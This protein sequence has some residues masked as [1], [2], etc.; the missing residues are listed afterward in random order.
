MKLVPNNRLLFLTAV[1]FLPVSLLVVALPELA[2][3]GLA[4]VIAFTLVAAGDAFVSRNYLVPVCVRLQD[5]VRVSLGRESEIEMIIDREGASVR[6]LRLGLSFPEEIHSPH[7]DLLVTLPRDIQS[8]LVNWPFKALQQGLYELQKCYL[9]APSKLGLWSLR[10]AAPAKSEIRVYPDLLRERRNLTA[11]FLNRGIGI[12]SR[13]QVGK[14]REFE[15]LREYMPGDS[16]EDIHWKATARRGFPITKVFQVERTQQIYVIV[17]AS[18]LSARYVKKRSEEDISA[19]EEVLRPHTTYLERFGVA[20]LALGLAADRQGDLFGLLVFDD[21]IRQ[22]VPAKNGKG[23]YN[24]CRDALYKLK[25]RQVAPDFDELFTF[26]ATKI[27]RRSLLLF[28]TNLDDP[29]L[30]DSFNANIDL[31]SRQHLVLVNMLQPDGADPLFSDPSIQ[32]VDDIYQKLGGHFLWKRLR[33][34]DKS[35]QRRGVKFSMLPNENLCADLISQYLT[36]KKRQ[37][38]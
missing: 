36:V 27:R 7:H 2:I 18:R 16:F 13:R 37:V 3:F 17:D 33:E 29:V 8:S 4:L 38:L 15:Q 26:I 19:E 14:G 23:H 12:H 24:V 5:V 32:S 20:A 22:F 30:A 28:L 31:I 25:P 35:L 21:Q 34:I 1:I 10:R 11:L 6:R 9:E